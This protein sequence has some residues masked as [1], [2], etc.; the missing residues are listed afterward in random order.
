MSSSDRR[1]QDSA[2][3]LNQQ[4]LDFSQ[5]NLDGKLQLIVEIDIDQRFSK[6]NTSVISI[7]SVLS[8]ILFVLPNLQDYQEGLDKKP[9]RAIV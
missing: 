6:R 1:P 5:D 9:L 2:T 3:V 8:L 7:S 4:L